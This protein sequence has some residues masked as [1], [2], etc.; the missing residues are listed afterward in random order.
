M[1]PNGV[2]L[3]TPPAHSLPAEIVEMVFSPTLSYIAASTL[4]QSASISTTT[5]TSP[6]NLTFGGESRP[7]AENGECR[8]LGPFALFIQGAL[9]VLALLV[10]VL[11]RWR[12]RPQR[13]L[14]IWAFD[15][16][17]QVV[18][19]ALLHVAN[20]IMSMLSSGQLTIK[21]GDYQANPCSFYLLNLAIDTTIGIPI[22]VVL[23]R[24]LTHAFSLTPLGNPAESIQSGNYG[25]P[26]RTKW[27]LKQ[28]FIY[29]LGLLGM[30]ACVFFIFQLCP[31]I[32]RVGD[33]ALRWTEGNEMV[34]VFFV[35]LFFP[36]VMNALQYYIIDSFIKDQKPS[37]HEPI[38]SEDGDEHSVDEHGRTRRRRSR[39]EDDD[40]THDTDT[41]TETTKGGAE[42]K[43]PEGK[44]KPKLKVEAKQLDEYDPAI[45]GEGSGS[46]GQ[47][48]RSPSPLK[49]T[50]AKLQRGHGKE[51]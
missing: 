12:E 47:P 14:K 42:I 32:I 13:P 38:P 15:A 41:G 21:A 43:V 17:K 16:S 24:L 51:S 22:L 25:R 36:V 34:Q 28:S 29:F 45:D 35:M 1:S 33:W 20:L 48:E 40:S 6:L 26:P 49:E 27:W 4:K 30:K 9:G 5:P 23:L 46:S 7:G 37:E 31:W 50:K 10:L 8:L 3:P 19:S 44:D 18:G 11:K 39:G 2:V